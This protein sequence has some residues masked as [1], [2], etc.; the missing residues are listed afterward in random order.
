MASTEK[1]F[2]ILGKSFSITRHEYIPCLLSSPSFDTKAGSIKLLQDDFI[3]DVSNDDLWIKYQPI[4]PSKEVLEKYEIS[5]E[6]FDEIAKEMAHVLTVACD[7]C[8][9]CTG[10]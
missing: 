7:H 6:L 2:T 4:A 8:G 3:Q 1:I 9:E 5:S 10:H